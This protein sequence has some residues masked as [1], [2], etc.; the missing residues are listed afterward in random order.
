MRRNRKFSL[1]PTALVLLIVLMLLCSIGVGFA[2]NQE[3]V[4]V[5][6]EKVGEVID[7]EEREKFQLFVAF[8]G[9]KS[10]VFLQ[11]PDGSYVAEITY[12]EDGEEKKTRLPQTEK[13]IESFRNYLE[14]YSEHKAKLQGGTIIKGTLRIPDSSYIQI[15]TTQDGSTL[16]GRIVEIGESE[17]QFESNLGKIAIP[18]SKIIEIKEI[19]VSSMKEGKYWFPNPNSTRLYFAPTGRSLKKGEGYFADYYLFFT[20]LA[21][22]VTDNITLSGGMSILP[23]DNFVEHNIFFFTPKVGLIQRD[24][25]ALSVGAL[26]VKLPSF[27]DSD[28]ASVGILYSIGTLGG[29]DR[30]ITA[31]LGY[32]YVDWDLADKPMFMVG[33]ESR[34]S[35]RVALVTENWMFPGVDQPLLISYGMRFFGKGLSVDLAFI[36]VL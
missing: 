16:I 19:P 4:I 6:S 3:K 34:V 8:K 10:A 36:N 1:S 5:I 27:E 25:G 21:V 31:G 12:E 33:G 26:M 23:T 30:S 29:P 22:G 17:I 35:R 15:L 11:L 28:A 18:I 2:Q 32:G 9:F 24:N 14:N 7:V 20:M 13:S